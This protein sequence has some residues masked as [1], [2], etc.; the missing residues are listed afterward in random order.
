M[1][2]NYSAVRLVYSACVQIER[3]SVDVIR[4]TFEQPRFG[5][6]QHQKMFAV[7]LQ[8]LSN[9]D[10]GSIAFGYPVGFHAA[11]GPS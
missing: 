9:G 5:F 1:P 8:D 10:S 7:T 11:L 3:R 2:Y 6:G 4:D